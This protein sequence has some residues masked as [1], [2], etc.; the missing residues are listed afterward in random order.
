MDTL[1]DMIESNH[2]TA[3]RV[4]MRTKDEQ[5]GLLEA[6]QDKMFLRGLAGAT[7]AKIE[8]YDGQGPCSYW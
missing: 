3:A 6:V 4:A 1:V 7:K 5:G 8:A 2:L